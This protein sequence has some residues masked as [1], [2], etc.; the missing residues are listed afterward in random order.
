MSSTLSLQNEELGF[1]VS[2]IAAA[3][4]GL[5]VERYPTQESR[6]A[7]KRS[8]RERLE[9][10]PGVS[11]VVLGGGFPPASDG[12]L[13]QVEVQGRSV[14]PVFDVDVIG[15]SREYFELFRVP[16]LR[17]RMFV[18]AD[19][20]GPP[21]A[22]VSQRF[23]DRYLAGQDPIGRAIRV[24]DP[25][26]KGDTRGEWKTIV[27]VIGPW[28]HMVDDTAW[29]DTPMIFSIGGKPQLSEGFS[30]GIGVRTNRD[31]ADIAQQMEK[32]IAIMEPHAIW[33][34]AESPSQRLNAMLAYPR[35][36]MLLLIA[37]GAG[38]L[39]LAAVGLHGVI[40]QLVSQRM[41]EFAIRSALGAQPVDLASLAA[42]QGGIAVLGGVIVGVVG[43]LATSRFVQSFVYG[44]TTNDPGILALAG[45]V[46]VASAALAVLLPV[47]R[48]ARVS[49]LTVLRQE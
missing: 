34:D 45:S 35:F 19:H 17:G 1:D 13:L 47:L 33:T 43:S 10:L 44:V 21:L 27:G 14:E 49:P 20:T 25:Y 31:T 9:S 5:P 7:F 36:R 15:A 46:L 11:Q 42:R 30:I 40:A 18:D 37:F 8:L 16:L 23:V 3:S 32:Q 2:N 12:G 39:L 38:A 41:P 26:A 48:A 24:I 29:R 6:D 4:A 28:K 22:I